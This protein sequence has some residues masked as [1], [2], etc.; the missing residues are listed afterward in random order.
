MGLK[1]AGRT[2]SRGARFLHGSARR[3]KSTLP[4]AGPSFEGIAFGTIAAIVLLC[5]L[6][7]A[8]RHIL[9][10]SER[11]AFWPAFLTFPVVLARLAGH[12]ATSTSLTFSTVVL[13]LAG[14]WHFGAKFVGR[15]SVDAILTALAAFEL[16]FF[17]RYINFLLPSAGPLSFGALALPQKINLI[18]QVMA[19]MVALCLAAATPLPTSGYGDSAPSRVTSFLRRRR[20]PWRVAGV[21]LM[22]LV[23]AG[24][25]ASGLLAFDAT[26]APEV[27]QAPAIFTVWLALDGLYFVGRAMW[28]RVH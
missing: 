19:A 4:G 26:D 9:G 18:L 17:F 1:F 14:V 5:V 28:Q 20:L 3:R 7:A 22:A 11:L 13:L 6:V 23:C 16:F 8:L 2:D 27:L 21:L 24:V 25:I 10:A 12:S 15:R